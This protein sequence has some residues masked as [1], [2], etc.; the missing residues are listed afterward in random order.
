MKKIVKYGGN[1]G[2]QWYQTGRERMKKCSIL[3]QRLTLKNS[4]IPMFRSGFRKSNANFDCQKQ[5]LTK[6]TPCRIYRK[7]SRRKKLIK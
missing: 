7:S 3:N 1:Q 2:E 4:R 5:K 6:N